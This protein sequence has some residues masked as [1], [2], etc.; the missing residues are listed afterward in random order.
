MSHLRT[1]T[2]DDWRRAVEAERAR[3]QRALL[4]FARDRQRREAFG[5][6]KLCLAMMAVTAIGWWLWGC[7]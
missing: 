1:A 3:R 7:V 2:D 5:V 4:E 6:V